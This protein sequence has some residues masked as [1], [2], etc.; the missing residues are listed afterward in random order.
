MS[1]QNERVEELERL[2]WIICEAG[3]NDPERMTYI[4]PEPG[5]Q[6][7]YGPA[8]CHYMREAEAALTYADERAATAREGWQPIETAPRDRSI[9]LSSGF[10]MRLG[11]WAVG[12]D[13]EN[14]GTVDGG[15]I[16]QAAAECTGPRGLRFAP[17][18]WHSLPAPPARDEGGE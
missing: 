13:H 16:D 7:P 2:A 9:W 6:E 11:F 15:W 12:K 5:V 4:T 18:S 3:G 14:F 1:E 8:W 17:T 10:A